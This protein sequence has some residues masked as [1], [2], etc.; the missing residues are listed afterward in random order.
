MIDIKQLQY[1]VVCA[2][3][4][5]FSEA[6]K[7]LY[8]TQSN[9]SK[10]IKALEDAAGIRLFDR[11]SRG[12]VLTSR[13]RHIYDYACRILRE[14]G[15]LEDYTRTGD[16][17]WLHIS[18]NPSSW[19]A[20]QF[21]GYYNENYDKNYHCQIYTASVKNIIR[22]VRDCKDD[23]GFV[24]VM[25]IQSDEFRY[26]MLQ[27]HLEFIPLKSISAMLYLGEKHPMYEKNDIGQEE[28]GKL[29]FVQNYQD[30]FTGDNY[31][32]VKDGEGKL[33]TEL[34]VTVV[35]NSDYIM[36]R[37]LKESPLANISG[38]YLTQG[39][40]GRGIPLGQEDDQVVFGYLK[41]MGEE[42]DPMARGFVEYI[43]AALKE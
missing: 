26:G 21:A 13:G 11:V 12:I 22:R 5:S 2:D 32:M 14:M 28:L 1:F 36:E 42:L 25:G 9:I 29:R 30:E 41:R 23:V 27:N 7:I 4:G 24:Y 43:E 3:V 15:E 19:F 18:C 16:A 37:M 35:T 6:A 8:T 40:A 34:D 20:G 17:K 31:W 39:K 33:L 10:V 38:D